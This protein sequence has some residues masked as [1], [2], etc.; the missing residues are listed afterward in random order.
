MA[1]ISEKLQSFLDNYLSAKEMIVASE[2]SATKTVMFLPTFRRLFP[3]AQL[4]QFNITRKSLDQAESYRYCQKQ[5]TSG[6]NQSQCL[7]ICVF[8]QPHANSSS[9]NP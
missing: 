8:T 2:G 3:A 4:E 5:C 6:E 9:L 1:D 7:G